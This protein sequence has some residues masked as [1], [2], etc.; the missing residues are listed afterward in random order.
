MV[1][2]EFAV[3]FRAAYADPAFRAEDAAIAK[4]EKIAWEGYANNR[5]APTTQPASTGFADSSYALSKEWLDTK[6]RIDAAEQ[7]QKNATSPSR[8]YERRA[9]S[10]TRSTAQKA[11]TKM[12]TQAGA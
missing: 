5:K 11:K 6:Q 8:M 7:Q 1:R 2:Q 9:T 12:K 3:R 4:L 10:A